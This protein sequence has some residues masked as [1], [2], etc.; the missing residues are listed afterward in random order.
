MYILF[1]H[2]LL[3][4]FYLVLLFLILFYKQLLN[5]RQNKKSSCG[6]NKN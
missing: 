2:N 5:L 1:D 4:T 6:G 3:A